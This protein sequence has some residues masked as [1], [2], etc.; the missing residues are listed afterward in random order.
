MS[1]DDF[2][3]SEL[4][5]IEMIESVIVRM[6]QNSFAIK[7]WTMTLIVAICGLSAVGSEKNFAI[8]AII[9]IIVFW[10]L[11]SFYLQRERKY[12][13]LYNRAIQHEVPT[14]S[15][16]VS[17]IHGDKTRYC[18]CILSPTESLFY[19]VCIATII[20]FIGLSEVQ[21]LW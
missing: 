6:G 1:N 16:D 10:F 4:K 3:E 9:P 19:C 11:D 17:S 20:A 13:E 14:L 8:F 21:I 12:R 2:K 15:L 18:K 7:G 5:H